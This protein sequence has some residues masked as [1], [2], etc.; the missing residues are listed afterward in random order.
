[1]TIGERSGPGVGAQPR[2]GLVGDAYMADQTVTMIHVKITGLLG[3][4]KAEIIVAQAAS[5]SDYPKSLVC[6]GAVNRTV[7]GHALVAGL[8]TAPVLENLLQGYVQIS[9]LGGAESQHVAAVNIPANGKIVSA[10]AGDSAAVGSISSTQS[11]A[12]AYAELAGNTTTPACILKTVSTCVVKATVVRTESRTTAKA[13]GASSVDSGTTIANLSVLGIPV[14][15][16]GEPN[17]VITVPGVGFIVINEQLCDNGVNTNTHTCSGAT[18]SGL[19]VR[20]IRVFITVANNLLG[21]TPGI[22]LVISEAHSDATFAQ[23]AG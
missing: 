11:T 4:Q 1:V 3:L 13:S 20:G 23:A 8:H 5:H 15:V 21:I 14:K 17:Q 16:T 22:D 12:H 7:S 9:P 10:L 6:S 18:H 19:T 2:A